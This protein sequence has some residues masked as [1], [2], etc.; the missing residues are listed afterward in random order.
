MENLPE[1]G[2]SAADKEDPPRWI[3]TA[4]GTTLS[5]GP[6]GHRLGMDLQNVGNDL[7]KRRRI[8]TCFSTKLDQ[9]PDQL[10]NRR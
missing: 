6:E 5:C 2:E 4:L 10:P 9:P 1:S 7:I 3:R 8:E